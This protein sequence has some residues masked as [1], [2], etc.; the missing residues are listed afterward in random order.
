MLVAQHL[1]GFLAELENT[2]GI[3]E[4]TLA[5]LG[6]QH[7][8]LAA[9]QQ[10]AVEL[11]FQAQHVLADGG[12]GEVQLFGGAGEVA[13]VHHADQAAQEDGIEHHD[14]HWNAVSH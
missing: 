8:A 1:A 3:A 14:S 12:L 13:G 2:P 9:I 5:F 7:L 11:L 4:Q 10:A 6:G